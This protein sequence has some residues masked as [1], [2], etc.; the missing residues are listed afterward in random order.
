MLCSSAAGATPYCAV[1]VLA[2][3][4]GNSQGWL[5]HGTCVSLCMTLHLCWCAVDTS[6]HCFVSRTSLVLLCYL[7]CVLSTLFCC[8]CMRGCLG[9]CGTVLAYAIPRKRMLQNGWRGG[10]IMHPRPS[11][12]AYHVP[13]VCDECVVFG[14]RQVWNRTRAAM[15]QAAVFWRQLSP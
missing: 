1:A 5:D 8:R 4:V 10:W 6:Q 7:C 15:H 14:K 9:I 13:A 2:A 3:G 11:C 12:C